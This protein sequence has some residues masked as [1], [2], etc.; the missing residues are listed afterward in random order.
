MVVKCKSYN[1]SYKLQK[2]QW[3][4]HITYDILKKDDSVIISQYAFLLSDKDV[5]EI[6]NSYLPFLHYEDLSLMAEINVQFPELGEPL[7]LFFHSSDLAPFKANGSTFVM[8]SFDNNKPIRLELNSYH[9]GEDLIML[10]NGQVN[11]DMIRRCSKMSVTLTDPNKPD[12]QITYTFTTKGFK[13]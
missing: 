3:S 9:K 11:V 13:L 7:S 8:I 10:P 12:S 6:N 2:S 1:A 4:Y 5:E